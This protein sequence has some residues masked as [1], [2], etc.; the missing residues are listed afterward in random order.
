MD[1]IDSPTTIAS[2]APPVHGRGDSPIVV[3]RL[4]LLTAHGSAQRPILTGLYGF[5][6]PESEIDAKCLHM[7]QALGDYKPGQRKLSRYHP[8]IPDPHCSCGIYAATDELRLED[9]PT[10]PSNTP[11]VTGFVA[12][13][14]QIFVDG[15]H[16]RA[17]HAS[18]VGPLS[19]SVGRRPRWHRLTAGAMDSR[20]SRVVVDHT[21]YRT[22][23]SRGRTGMSGALWLSKTSHALSVRYGVGVTPNG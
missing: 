11:Y 10:P 15:N 2:P 7:D 20:P 17:Q 4:W 6:W 16:L 1:R 8:V 19:L 14:G 3:M 21:R 9:M 18:I 5:R 23:W 13:S 22:I 12:L